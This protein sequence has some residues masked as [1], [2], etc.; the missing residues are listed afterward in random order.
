MPLQQELFVMCS[1]CLALLSKG[2]P[3]PK[4]LPSELRAADEA[5]PRDAGGEALVRLAA[6]EQLLD[7]RGGAAERGHE[8][9]PGA[10]PDELTGKFG[11]FICRLALVCIETDFCEF[12]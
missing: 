10:G 7:R 11:K 12:A 8:G 6:R 3:S 5:R 4:L 1:C 2:H 9:P